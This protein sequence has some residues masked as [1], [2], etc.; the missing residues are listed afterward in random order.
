MKT[1]SS[2]LGTDQ[3]LTS[4]T[5]V[6]ITRS[7]PKQRLRFSM[8][9]R[10]LRIVI[11]VTVGALLRWPGS[12][13]VAADTAPALLKHQDAM[14]DWTTDAPGVRRLITIEVLSK[15]YASSSNA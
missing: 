12:N 15:R 4:T 13:A 5:V 6:F 11:A 2:A 9:V 1:E 7:M 8:I 3:L 14:G 10:H